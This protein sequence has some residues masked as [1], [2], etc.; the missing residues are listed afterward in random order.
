MSTAAQAQAGRDRVREAAEHA[1]AT[2]VERLLSECLSVTDVA[3]LTG[4]DLSTVRRLRHTVPRESDGKVIPVSNA[5]RHQPNPWARLG[6]SS[7]AICPDAMNRLACGRRC[8]LTT[9]WR[10]SLAA[11]RGSTIGNAVGEPV[12]QR[13]CRQ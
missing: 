10:R 4:M 12:P 9:C 3:K 7:S 5:A 6:W 11:A 1:A 8:V 2:A 13:N